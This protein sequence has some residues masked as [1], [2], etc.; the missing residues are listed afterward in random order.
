MSTRP[1]PP[2][3][4]GV[5]GSACSMRALDVA[6]TEAAQRKRPLQ[7]IHAFRWPILFTPLGATPEPDPRVHA[8]AVTAAAVERARAAQPGLEVTTSIIDGGPV[9]RGP[10]AVLVHASDAASLVVVG[11]RGTGGFANLLAGSV[12]VQVA[13]H[14]Q[15][16]VIVVRDEP[17]AH[18]AAEPAVVVGVDGSELSA[19]AVW[20]AFEEASFR[21]MPL[22]AIQVLEPAAGTHAAPTTTPPH[23]NDAATAYAHRILADALAPARARHPDV[24]VK[25][26]V[27]EAKT[28]QQALIDASEGATMVVVGPRGRGGFRGLLFGSVSQAVLHHA[29]CPVALV[30][31]YTRT[32]RP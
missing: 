3:I 25:S 13:T 31:N 20:F 28:P 8:T 32:A 16:P 27:V 26:E 12:S 11:H 29:H 23:R 17:V 2:V 6:A 21:S 10:A 18:A 1:R 19:Q 4:V 15:C 22:I 30:R 7:V 5:D 14:A 9:D 24:A